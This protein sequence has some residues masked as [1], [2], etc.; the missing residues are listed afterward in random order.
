[1]W[2]WSQLGVFSKKKKTKQNKKNAG[3]KVPYEINMLE[4]D[5]EI[6]KGNILEVI[7]KQGQRKQKHALEGGTC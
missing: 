4:N 7:G 2:L 5:P 6:G 3:E 1:M